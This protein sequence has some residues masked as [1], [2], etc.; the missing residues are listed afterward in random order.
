MSRSRLRGGFMRKVYYG[1]DGLARPSHNPHRM[2]EA[3]KNSPSKY[4]SIHCGAYVGW[5]Q[6]PTSFGGHRIPRGGHRIV[7]GL[8]RAKVKRTVRKEIEAALDE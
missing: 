5:L 2:D 4:V 6:E 8:V 7:S 3:P 1:E